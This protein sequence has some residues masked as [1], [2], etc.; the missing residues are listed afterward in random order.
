[1]LAATLDEAQ[2]ET[3]LLLVSGGND[4]RAGAWGG[5]AQLAARLAAQGVPV[6][7]FDRRGVGD[8]EG[9]NGGYR[10]SRDDIAAALAAFRAAVPHL[11]RVV[12]YGNCDAASALM[13]FGAGLELDGLV[14]ANPWTFETGGE[15]EHAPQALRQR[16][17]EKLADPREWRR[18]LTGAVDLGK[19]ARGLRGAVRAA[20]ASS[21][22]AEMRAGLARFPGPV[23]ILLAER[24]RTAAQFLADWGEGDPRIHR[25]A[26][27]S[28]SFAGAAEREWLVEEVLQAVR[29]A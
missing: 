9:E 1:M 22:A 4:V 20:A 29:A 17:R 14:L 23:V 16:Y 25:I 18:L 27:A 10:A 26:S 21:L 12:A 6:L 5:Q 3:G 13:L 19:L 24:D 11:R 2:G 28:H 15:T 8:S 7:R